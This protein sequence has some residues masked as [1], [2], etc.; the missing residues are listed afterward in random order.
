VDFIET[1]CG[2][3]AVSINSTGLSDLEFGLVVVSPKKAALILGCSQG[4]IYALINRGEPEGL[5]SYLDDGGRRKILL[6][7]ILRYQARQLA[8]SLTEQGPAK[9]GKIAKASEAALKGARA[10][11]MEKA[12]RIARA[13]ATTEATA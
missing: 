7:S 8:A 9:N 4:H 3:T 12:R 6:A 5:L 10:R 1:T 2:G 11:R 13:K